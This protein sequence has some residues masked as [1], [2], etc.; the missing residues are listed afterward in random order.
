MESSDKK[1]RINNLGKRRFSSFSLLVM[2]LSLVS[3]LVIFLHENFDVS[4][5]TFL[6]IFDI[7]V[8]VFFIFSLFL[9]VV[10]ISNK[11]YIYKKYIL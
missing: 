11:F 6:A 10:D 8:L 9:S 3:S 7:S 1:C 2:S 4:Y 5:N